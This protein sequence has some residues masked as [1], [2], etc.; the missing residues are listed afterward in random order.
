VLGFVCPTADQ[1]YYLAAHAAV[2]KVDDSGNVLNAVDGDITNSFLDIDEDSGGS[3]DFNR[4]GWSN[5]PVNGSCE[6]DIYAGAGQSDITKGTLVGTL[7]VVVEGTTADVTF[8][9][10]SAYYMEENPLYVGSEIVARDVNGDFTVA[11]GQYPTIHDQLTGINQNLDMYT[12]AVNGDFFVV[13]HATV[14]G[15]QD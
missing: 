10:D 4:W 8:D 13:A 14:C 6:W 9:I 5:G 11:P 12:I 7:Y 2:Q 15:F 3:G 1:A